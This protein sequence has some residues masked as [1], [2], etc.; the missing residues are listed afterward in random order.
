MPARQVL[1]RAAH[2]PNP[3]CE[4]QHKRFLGGR[5][6]GNAP[7]LPDNTFASGTCSSKSWQV[8][9][10]WVVAANIAADLTAWT[11]LLGFGDDPDLRE[12]DPDILRYL[13]WHLPARLARH[14]ANES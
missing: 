6:S 1:F 4:D 11:R 3:L 9:R 7:R 8:N 2:P 13:V 12:A 10:G 14:A 5:G